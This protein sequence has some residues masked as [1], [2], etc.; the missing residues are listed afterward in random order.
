MSH[1][2][3]AVEVVGPF[4]VSDDVDNSLGCGI[5]DDKEEEGCEEGR[6]GK[7]EAVSEMSTN[8]T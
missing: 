8:S 1:P 6:S 2:R 5:D 3:D 7:K 4:V